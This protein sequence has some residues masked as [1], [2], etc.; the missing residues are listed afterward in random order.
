LQNIQRGLNIFVAFSSHRSSGKTRLVQSAFKTV[1]LANGMLI[2]R[3]FEETSNNQLSVVTSAFDDLCVI[4]AERNS[5]NCLQHIWQRLMSEFGTNMHLLVRLLPNVLRLAP[6]DSAALMI[7]GGN[8]NEGGVNFFSLCDNIQRFMRVIS[9]SSCPVFLFLDDLQ[10]SNCADKL[11]MYKFNTLMIVY[12]F[13]VGRS[14]QSWACSH[15]AC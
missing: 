10:V 5:V 7:D 2:T 1:F 8:D 13:A 12:R 15:C 6:S 9:S 11:T 3:K 4:L 14:G